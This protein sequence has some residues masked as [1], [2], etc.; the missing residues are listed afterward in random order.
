LGPGDRIAIFHLPSG[1]VEERRY[2]EWLERQVD[3][4]ADDVT[5]LGEQYLGL[6]RAAVRTRLRERTA[7]HCSGGMDSTGVA[8]IARDCL[9][10]R[11][12]LHALAL[13]YARL[14]Y[15][16]RERPYIE[17]A[18]DQ[19]GLAPHRISGDEI[20]PYGLANLLPAWMRIGVGA[21][22]RGG[23]TR[24]DRM[25]QWTI[26]PW[27]RSDFAR[28]LDLHG[29][30]VAHLRR[31]YHAI[32]PLRLSLALSSLRQSCCDFARWYLAASH[33]MVQTN[34]YLDPRV[35]SLGVGIQSRFRPQPGGQKPILAA[36]MRG[37]LPDCI[38]NRPSKGHFNEPYYLGLSRHL[39]RM[40]TLVEQ[41]P[42]DDL[43]F[44]DKPV[45]LDCLQRAALGNASDAPAL[46]SM[47]RTLSL[48]L[49]L[50][51]QRGGLRRREPAAAE[52]AAA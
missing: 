12:P 3:P 27:I 29:R 46:Q 22:L 11:E 1:E 15:L 35:L 26:A 41:A 33:G 6:L 2:W 42:V 4:G 24:W 8:L 5:Q 20:G 21:S 7:S 40:E 38:L 44:L 34:P 30:S 25:S 28:R 10:G 45:L 17:T 49:W 13:V 14:P 50:T 51:Q 9:G 37:I 39:R 19:P 32:R 23:H 48:L 18:L 47:D 16:A 36:A 31:T 43:G 52:S